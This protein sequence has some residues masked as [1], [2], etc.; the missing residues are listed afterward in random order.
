MNLRV[1]IT[2]DKNVWSATP[3][4]GSVA[5]DGADVLTLLAHQL[6]TPL[7]VIDGT[8][9]RLIRQSNVIDA[10]GIVERSHRI[11]IA[12][13]ELLGLVRALLDKINPAS[14]QVAPEQDLC[15]LLDIV[16]RSC[17]HVWCDQPDRKFD[18]DISAQADAIVGDPIL[19]QQMMHI[20]VSNASKYSSEQ[21]TIRI[22]G[23]IVDGYLLVSVKDSGIGIPADDQQQLFQPFFRARNATEHCGTGLGLSLARRIARSHG[24]SIRVESAEGYGSTFT[25][26]LP[27]SQP[28]LPPPL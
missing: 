19:L 4:L 28:P 22:E 21:T 17:K 6:L 7:A 24:G 11:R 26:A 20:L 25:V 8:A 2:L 18:I 14:G 23:S 3:G 15:S 10:S 16:S 9:Q 12:A 1:D 27:W 13:E 5:L